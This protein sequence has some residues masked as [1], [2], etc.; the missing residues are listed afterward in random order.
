MIDKLFYTKDN[1]TLFI[2]NILYNPLIN[3]KG[4][5]RFAMEYSQAYNFYN[6]NIQLF[7]KGEKKIKK[8][9]INVMK[10]SK[11]FRL[12]Y[13]ESTELYKEEKDVMRF[14]RGFYYN[15]FKSATKQR[16]S[17]FVE[18]INKPEF[19]IYNLL[20]CVKKMFGYGEYDFEEVKFKIQTLRDTKK[21]ETYTDFSFNK[22]KD[23]MDLV[24]MC[25][26]ITN[27]RIREGDNRKTVKVFKKYKMNA[28]IK[29]Y[30]KQMDIEMN[31]DDIYDLLTN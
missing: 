30:V 26:D 20:D 12:S 25:F 14:V 16:A 21:F 18:S 10:Y 7:E 6:D 1:S 3:I 4:K 31:N 5:R 29:K 19:V 28:K 11:Y 27:R 24:N 13:T 9:S 22:D 15:H 23:I 17:W 2:E 8:M